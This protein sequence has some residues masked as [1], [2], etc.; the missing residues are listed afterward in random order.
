MKKFDVIVVGA[1]HAGVEASLIT[2]RLGLQT[3]L[4][5]INKEKIATMHCNSSIGELARGT[6]V[7]EIDVL[8]GEIVKATDKS[9]FDF[10]ILNTS[11][12][13]AVWSLKAFVDKITYFKYMKQ[14]IYKAT[15][16]TIIEGLADSLII[17]KSVVKGI[18]LEDNSEIIAKKAIL[19]T[20]TYLKSITY[21]GNNRVASGPEDNKSSFNLSEQLK[22]LDFEIVR[23]KTGTLPRISKDSVDY[24]KTTLLS[25]R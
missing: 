23:L 8:G 18:K 24:S 3:C 11:K 19:T 4:L 14:V 20:G 9:A 15:N 7:R 2:S 21:Q 6:A 17:D 10:K 1:G 13:P 25:R 5:T 16:L 12:G 22:I